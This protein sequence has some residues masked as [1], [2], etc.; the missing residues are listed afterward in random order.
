M[1]TR[2]IN[3]AVW[4]AS[5][6]LTPPARRTLTAERPPL[7][8]STAAGALLLP[9]YM[10]VVVQGL[11]VFLQFLVQLGFMAALVWIFR[12]VR[13]RNRPTPMPA[14]CPCDQLWGLVTKARCQRSCG[15]TRRGV[16]MYA[17]QPAS[18]LLPPLTRSQ[19]HIISLESSIA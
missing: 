2:R 17:P 18:R 11:V 10:N 1:S 9:I 14:A 3:A 15:P 16:V 7:V 13:T 19:P 4:Q 8:L 12:P 5:C 6:N